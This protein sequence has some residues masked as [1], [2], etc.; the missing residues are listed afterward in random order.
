MF[1]H[2]TF[3][4]AI[5]SAPKRVEIF[6]VASIVGDVDGYPMFAGIATGVGIGTNNLGLD[7]RRSQLNTPSKTRTWRRI[8]HSNS[9]VFIPKNRRSRS[10]VCQPRS[11]L[12][13]C[14]GDHRHRLS[15]RLAK[16]QYKPNA[17]LSSQT[18]V[19]VFSEIQ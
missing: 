7:G 18:E 11:C 17:S 15:Q 9:W 3:K 13:L 19:V 4:Q 14:I 8:S 10:D 16:L 5:R 1:I 2:V 6:S 12:K